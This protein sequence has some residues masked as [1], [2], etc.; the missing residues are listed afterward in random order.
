[1]FDNFVA[2]NNLK[3]MRRIG[4]IAIA[5]TLFAALCVACVEDQIPIFPGLNTPNGEE[6]EE[7]PTPEPDAPL[8]NDYP[9]TEWAAGE[10]DWLFDMNVLPE[11]RIE[12]T[13][14][15]WNTL[16]AE[17]DRDSNTNAYVHCDVN[18]KSKGE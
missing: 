5:I 8:C 18:F 16:L 6:D 9:N 13:Q 10:L 15:Q 3:S 1:M 2:I 12:V 17:Y 4:F 14:E 11:I 7:Q